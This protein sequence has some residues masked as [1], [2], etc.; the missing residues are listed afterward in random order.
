MVVTDDTARAQEVDLKCSEK[1]TD[2]DVEE[3]N[4]DSDHLAAKVLV[5]YLLNTN[6]FAGQM[7]RINS[8]SLYR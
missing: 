2:S 4:I 8:S 6:D 3:S 5:A 1:V 7:Y